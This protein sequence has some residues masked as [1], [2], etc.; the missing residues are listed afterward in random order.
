MT[1]TDLGLP[2]V[3][4]LEQV[5]CAGQPYTGSSATKHQGEPKGANLNDPVTTPAGIW[6]P[7]SI[8][9]G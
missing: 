8:P 5:T 7:L 9:A 6:Y 4:S 2:G 3:A 1:R